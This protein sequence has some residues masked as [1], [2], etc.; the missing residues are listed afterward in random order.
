M[1]KLLSF[2]GPLDRYRD[3]AP[4]FIRL[5]VG[6]HLIHGTQDNVF[7]WAQMLE[8][9]DFLAVR[10]VPFPLFAAHLS[11]Y[12]QFI[13]GIL[14]LLGAQVRLA[15]LVMVINFIAALIIAHRHTSYPQT[16]PALMMLCAALFLLLNGAGRP[17]I[18]HYL[19]RRGR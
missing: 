6:F 16:F 11:V 7:S 19:S 10:G 15:A 14:Y 4:L 12:A 8:F 5:I 1:N 3:Y 2:L 18:D 13:C 17:S 9:R